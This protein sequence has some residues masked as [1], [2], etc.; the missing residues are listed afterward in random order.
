MAG[1]L[2]G[3]SAGYFFSELGAKVIKVEN[4]KTNGDVT[5]SWKLKKENPKDNTS[6]YFWSVNANKE[7]L[8]LDIT[9]TKDLEKLYAL[10]R[11]ADIVITNYKKG[12][13]EK[14]KVDYT[15]LKALK[16][17]IIY[18]SINGFGSDSPRTAY[19]LI[20]QAESGFMSMNG[21]PKVYP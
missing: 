19:D 5:R 9:Q 2:A 8:F 13:D 6:A 3:P 10:I 18:A 12:D 17:D 11:E 7:F 20:L 4:P 21:E 1:V 14:L 16:S 15:S